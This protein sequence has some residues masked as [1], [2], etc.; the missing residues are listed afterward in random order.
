[1]LIL[2]ILALASLSK[3]M[4]ELANDAEVKF[5]NPLQFYGE[6]LCNDLSYDEGESANAISRLLPTLQHVKSYIITHV[7][8]NIQE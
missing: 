3:E 1:M 2:V 4:D 6:G 8:L 5:Y 7:Q